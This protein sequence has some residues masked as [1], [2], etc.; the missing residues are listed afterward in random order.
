MMF[1]TINDIY[2]FVY[3]SILRSTKPTNVVITFTLLS[4][5]EGKVNNNS[6]RS[7]NTSVR[8]TLSI[9]FQIFYFKKRGRKTGRQ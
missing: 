5:R 8:E 7:S 3:F 4:D 1:C 9:S 2:V 6:S